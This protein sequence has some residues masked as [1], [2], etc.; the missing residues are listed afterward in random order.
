M[1]LLGVLGRDAGMSSHLAALQHG[2][3]GE[4]LAVRSLGYCLFA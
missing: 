2:G 1:V 4:Q 3:I